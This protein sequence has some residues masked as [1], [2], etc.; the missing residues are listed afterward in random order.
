M[1]QEDEPEGRKKM[2]MEDIWRA[3]SLEFRLTELIEKLSTRVET[4]DH[5]S[6]RRDET[7]ERNIKFIIEQ[8]AQFSADMQQMREAQ[9]QEDEKWERRW[10]RT[11]GGIRDLLAIAE[12]HDQEIKDLAKVQA[13]AQA[14]TDR[15]MADTDERLNA[16]VN[17]VEK[18]ISERRNGG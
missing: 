4:N 9:A 5:E 12:M 8:Q 15:Q 13:E 1:S 7:N 11:E 6:R 17:V 18:M 14:R 16:L 3:T 10:G 2:E